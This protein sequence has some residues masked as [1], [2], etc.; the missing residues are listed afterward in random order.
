MFICNKIK[1][2]QILKKKINSFNSIN[3]IMTS[4]LPEF[5]IS[6]QAKLVK[7]YIY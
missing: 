6:K 1:A 4:D 5:N 3:I 2:I 7:E